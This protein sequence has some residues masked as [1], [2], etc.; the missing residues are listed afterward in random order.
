MLFNDFNFTFSNYIC[1]LLRRMKGFFNI[2]ANSHFIFQ[3]IINYVIVEN[4]LLN[5]NS[6]DMMS[7]DI[8]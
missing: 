1:N 5:N 7:F 6:Y 3:R 8:F 2:F 4:S